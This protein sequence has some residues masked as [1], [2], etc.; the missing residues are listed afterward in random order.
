MVNSANPRQTATRLS[1]KEEGLL[2]RRLELKTV[3][4]T[5]STLV[6]TR[7]GLHDEFNNLTA[8]L[9]AARSKMS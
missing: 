6:A 8:A 5:I 3:R 4:S 9:A 2:D 1:T 7:D